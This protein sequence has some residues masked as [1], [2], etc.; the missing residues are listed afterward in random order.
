VSRRKRRIKRKRKPWL[1]EATKKN[2]EVSNSLVTLLDIFVAEPIREQ[3]KKDVAAAR[4][5][6][7]AERQ[8]NK[9]LAVERTSQAQEEF[10][11]LDNLLLSSLKTDNSID[12]NS[13]NDTSK[14]GETMPAMPVQPKRVSEKS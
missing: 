3:R 11:M 1:Y 4:E 8:Y 9:Q 14:C 6:L 12:W 10:K 5:S 13:M 7:V 2:F